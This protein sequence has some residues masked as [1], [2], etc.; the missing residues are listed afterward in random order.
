LLQSLLKGPWASTPSG[1][2][3]SGKG[4]VITMIRAAL[5]PALTTGIFCAGF[6]VVVN[7]LTSMLSVG[8]TVTLAFASG[9]L[10]SLFAWFVLRRRRS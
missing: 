9:F 8:G 5:I 10:G 4:A 3:A 7:V 1:V 6:A 2:A